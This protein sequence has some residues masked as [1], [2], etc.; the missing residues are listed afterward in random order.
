MFEANGLGPVELSPFVCFLFWMGVTKI[1][2]V[3]KKTVQ[4]KICNNKLVIRDQVENG[5]DAI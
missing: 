3:I 2:T 1:I 4:R 5:C